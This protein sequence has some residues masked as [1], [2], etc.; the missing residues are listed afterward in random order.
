MHFGWANPSQEQRI[1]TGEADSVE[2]KIEF[3]NEEF[4]QLRGL[5]RLAGKDP[6]SYVHRQSL[7]FFLPS[8][9]D[10]QEA[11]RRAEWVRVRALQHYGRGETKEW[12]VGSAEEEAD[13]RS[14]F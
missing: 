4:A 10:S 2:L 3:T 8:P 7:Q 5:A 14:G 12:A 1:G 6:Q 9:S 13:L 11:G